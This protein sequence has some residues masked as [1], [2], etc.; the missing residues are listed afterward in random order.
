MSKLKSWF[1]VIR[2][3]FLP[4]SIVLVLLG[5]SIAFYEG[6]FN[7][8]YFFL[9]LIGLV[10]LHIAVDV[11]NEYYDYKSGLDFMTTKTPFSGGSG[12]LPAGG[13]D[14][15][16]VYYLGL[17]CCAIGLAIGIYFLVIRGWVLL[18]II[19]LGAIAVYFY[20]TL[21]SKIM[22][23]EIFAGL[24]MGFLPVLGAYLVQTGFYT[25]SIIIA[26]IVPGILVYNLLLLNEFPDK[27]ADKKVG[28]KNFVIILGKRGAGILYTIL[29][30]YIYVWIG[31]SV[32]FEFMPVLCLISFLTLPFAFKAIR[33]ALYDYDVLEKIV[34]ALGANVA[35]VLLTQVLLALG[36]FLAKVL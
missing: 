5:T 2:A 32:W 13:L 16:K 27:E 19:I 8:F 1:F 33:G 9:A 17:V 11:L 24:G 34:P 12:V 35:V 36:Y 3:P 4:L 30:F 21:L 15:K 20:N 28:K 29:T 22:L 7:P 25:D 10:V 23:G 31:I 18:P 26:A 6:F 14:P